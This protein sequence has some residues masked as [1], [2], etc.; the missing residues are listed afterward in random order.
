M[1]KEMQE[2]ASATAFR[3]LLRCEVAD[4]RALILSRV[5]WMEEVGIHQ[6]NDTD[7][8]GVYPPAYY[9]EC[10]ERGELFGL[11]S[12]E[13]EMLAVAALK[14]SDARWEADGA[15]A[16]YVHHLASRIGA[17]G[18][19]SACLFAIEAHARKTGKTHVR[20]DSAVDNPTLTA[21]Y[22]S[23]GYTPVGCCIDG[24]YEGI[25]REKKL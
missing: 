24:A 2:M 18:A 7:Y 8:D 3:P 23:R 11:F 5:A 25:L 17:R 19:G 9:E 14:E 10:F 4:M 13:G 22:T 6:W 1:N 15:R 20:L 21:Y 16:Y 12:A